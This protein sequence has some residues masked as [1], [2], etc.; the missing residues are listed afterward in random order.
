V[1]KLK[2]LLAVFSAVAI[3]LSSQAAH[4]THFR[5]GNVSYTIPDP[6]HAPR[7]VRFEVVA[8][9]RSEFTSGLDISRS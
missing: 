9:W 4:A 5:Y 7:S 3:I 2:H 1:S 6:G 8:G